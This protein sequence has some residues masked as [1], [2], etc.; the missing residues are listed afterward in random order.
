LRERRFYSTGRR[1]HRMADVPRHRLPQRGEPVDLQSSGDAGDVAKVDGEHSG[2]LQTLEH[3]HEAAL[4]RRKS[5]RH[6]LLRET[7][8]GDLVVTES[9][10]LGKVEDHAAG[11]AEPLVG[12]AYPRRRGADGG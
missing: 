1:R 7:E 4:A 8:A 12:R 5:S 10:E 3:A 11:Q 9:A 2:R 6:P